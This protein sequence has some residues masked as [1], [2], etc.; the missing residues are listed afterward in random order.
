MAARRC[1]NH[2]IPLSEMYLWHGTSKVSPDVVATEGLKLCY[3][4]SSGL[5]G[6]G[7]Y[8]AV[9]PHYSKDYTHRPDNSRDTLQL[10]LCRFLLGNCLEGSGGS[11][12]SD[13]LPPK[14]GHSWHDKGRNFY[15]VYDEGHVYPEF[16]VTFSK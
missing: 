9:D 5:Y 4:Q 2:G 12:A 6:K 15:V 16:V 13:A 11:R 14:D 3:A 10:I 8:G 1:Q 7:L